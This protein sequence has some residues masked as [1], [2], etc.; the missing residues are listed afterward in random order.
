MLANIVFCCALK[1]YSINKRLEISPK[2]NILP[3]FICKKGK[4]NK[5]AQEFSGSKY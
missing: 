1:H 5:F 2:I 4:L 3:V